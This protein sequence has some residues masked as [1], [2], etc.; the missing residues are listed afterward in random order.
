MSEGIPQGETIEPVQNVTVLGTATSLVGVGFTI[1]AAAMLNPALMV[2]GTVAAAA[3]AALKLHSS[4]RKA[5]RKT[6]G[7][8]SPSG[9]TRQA[10]H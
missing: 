7:E 10:E 5:A 2:A 1:A 3:G 8:Q 4:R 6:A 9:E